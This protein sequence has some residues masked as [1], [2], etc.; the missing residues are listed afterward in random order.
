MLRRIVP[1]SAAAALLL[2]GLA[3]CSAQ[4]A[5]SD[6]CSAGMQ[7]GVLSDGVTVLGSFGE[8]PEVSVPEDVEIVT[9]QR[10]I[11]DEVEED[12][13]RQ[14]E[15]GTLVGVDMA[16]FDG[17]TGEQVYASSG[18]TGG[19][20]EFMLVDEEQTTPL[21]EALRCAVA[22]ERVVLGLS[23]ED[24]APL[25]VQLDGTPGATMV[26]VLDVV[27]VSGM[28]AQG[29][30]RGLPAGFPSV[31]TNADGRPGIVLPPN[32]AP[33]GTTA[34]VRIEGDGPEIAADSNVIAQV[35]EVGWDGRQISNTWT[36]GPMGLGNEEQIVQ[37]GYTYR[38]A[39]TGKTV[40]SQVVIIENEG[41][42]EP[43][44]LV[45][46]ILGVA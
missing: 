44:V 12:R 39:L 32:S 21:T 13:G 8:M 7:P 3:A 5:A 14:V 36:D 19:P 15:N 4:N 9:S 28:S 10:T 42:S 20:G 1:A 41:D 27:S 46:D 37:S 31:V 30:A 11:V 2:T 6:D 16:F 18:F 35:L 25:A 33:S 23:P 17:A 24:A 34:A 40:G 43:R 38:A 45:V 26:G 29:A 22:G